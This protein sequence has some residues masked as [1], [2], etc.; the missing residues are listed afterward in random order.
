MED[1]GRRPGSSQ[2]RSWCFPASVLTWISGPR[3]WAYLPRRRMNG[4]AS[5]GMQRLEAENSA[6]GNE[7]ASGCL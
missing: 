7:D 4:R 2:K 6:V 5:K 1:V 3:T